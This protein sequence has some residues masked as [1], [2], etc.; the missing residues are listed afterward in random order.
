MANH[1]RQFILQARRSDC[2]LLL[3]SVAAL[4]IPYIRFTTKANAEQ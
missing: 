3:I 4:I 2:V 1:F